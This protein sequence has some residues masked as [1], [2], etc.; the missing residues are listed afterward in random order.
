MKKQKEMTLKNLMSGISREDKDVF[1]RVIEQMARNI[2]KEGS[3]I[4]V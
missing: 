1:I 2:E 4:H 3:D